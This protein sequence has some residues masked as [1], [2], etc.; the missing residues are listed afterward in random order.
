MTLL[1]KAKTTADRAITDLDAH[2]HAT[3]SRRRR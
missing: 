1:E 2:V 3:R